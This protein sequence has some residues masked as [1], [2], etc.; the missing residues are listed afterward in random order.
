MLNFEKVIFSLNIWVT[1]GIF[2]SFPGKPIFGS[3]LINIMV[4]SNLHL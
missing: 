4:I 2:L 3:K 1:Y